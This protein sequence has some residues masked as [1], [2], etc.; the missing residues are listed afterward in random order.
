MPRVFPRVLLLLLALPVAAA[1]QVAP[2]LAPPPSPSPE[3]RKFQYSAYEQATID[4]ALLSLGIA[5]ADRPEGKVV[6]SVRTVRLEVIE[7]RDPAPRFL[8]VFHSL[9]REY[10]VERELLLR[11]GDVYRQTLADE[12]QRR[13]ASIPQ[14]SLVLV[15]AAEGSTQ[16]E[17][18]LVVI[19]KDVWSLRLNWN[20]ALTG[21]GLEGL[22]INPAE[23]NLLGTQQTVGLQINWLPQSYS[24]GA[25]YEI[26]RVLGSH[27]SAFADAGITFNSSTGVREGSYGDLELTYPLWSSLTEWSWGGGVSWLTEVT[28]RYSNGHV[29]SVVLD[30]RTSCAQPSSLCV[31]DAYLTDITDAAAFVT[32]SFGWVSKFDVTAGFE[33]RRSRFRLPDLSAFDPATVDAYRRSRLPLSDDRVG[34]YLQL[35]AYPTNFLRVLDLETLALQEDYRLGPEGYLRFYPVLRS[36]GSSRDFLGLSAGASQTVSIADGLLRAGMEAIAE[37]DAG[38]HQVTDG[39]L[40]ATLRGASPRW[41][42]GRLVVDASLLN[43]YANH[44][45]RLTSLG[46][47][48]RLRGYPSQVLI[49]PKV[50]TA[51]AELRSRPW[52]L[53]ESLQAG[54]V[55]FYDAG[56]AFF[57]SK[58]F[59]LR[60]GAGVGV[61]IL[62]PQLDRVVF[63]A[64]VGFPITR[65]VPGGVAPATFFVTF[66][67][68]F[69]LYEIQPATA[70]TR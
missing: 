34:P 8:N 25:Q 41:S 61:R 40:K 66:G 22:S 55:L 65:D 67:Q 42:L 4:E 2:S 10:V 7:E 63:R 1:A 49:G 3:T 23:T 36:L 13:L 57:G 18:R 31:P 58:D 62:F 54:G 38:S 68:A 30:P 15:V 17:V 16:G 52:Q 5:R 45:N 9:T 51:N 70:I 37:V 14:L 26:P 56:D 6:E 43:R 11:P 19:T 24:L 28:R 50:L 48:S 20:I 39:S 33:A 21:T 53:F 69:S 59:E 32:R 27:V 44:L 64:D 60:Q 35:R 46:G 12:T 29:V 47:D